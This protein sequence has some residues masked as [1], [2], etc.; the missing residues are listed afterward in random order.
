MQHAFVHT[1]WKRVSDHLALEL[2]EA[3]SYLTWVPG[4]KLRSLK[5]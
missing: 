1:G 2:K 4:T 5:E 3:V